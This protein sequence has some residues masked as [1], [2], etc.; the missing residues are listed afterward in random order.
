[1][2]NPDYDPRNEDLLIKQDAYDRLVNALGD[3]LADPENTGERL[4]DNLPVNE[5]LGELREEGLDVKTRCLVSA[6][7]YIEAF[8]EVVTY[9]GRHAEV[10]L[11]I[12]RDKDSKE[13]VDRYRRMIEGEQ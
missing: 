9:P 4:G 8:T 6:L 11:D 1:M 7:A 3:H 5:C 10:S 13:Y 2:L 12:I